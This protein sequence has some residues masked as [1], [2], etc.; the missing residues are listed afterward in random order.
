MDTG[1]LTLHKRLPSLRI[2]AQSLGYSAVSANRAGSQSTHKL[3][4][5]GLSSGR[6]G[7]PSELMILPAPLTKIRTI[8]IIQGRAAPDI[9]FTIVGR[10]PTYLGII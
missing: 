1:S 3:R 6:D 5:T 10:S 7:F 4:P 9:V 8:S 2:Q